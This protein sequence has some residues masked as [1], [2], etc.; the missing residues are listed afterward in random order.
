M[1]RLEIK[2]L[3][4]ENPR[5]NNGMSCELTKV[6]KQ[7]HRELDCREMINSCLCYSTDFMNSHYKDAYIKDLGEQ[8]VIELYNEQKKDF[9]KAIVIHDVD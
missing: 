7:L 2:K 6:Q 3:R 8:R 9:E 1:T 4:K 5:F